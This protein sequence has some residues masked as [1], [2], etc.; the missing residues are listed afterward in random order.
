MTDELCPDGHHLVIRYGKFGKFLACE[1]FP[2]HKFTKRIEE[3]IDAL[4]PDSG[5][6]VAFRR[7]KRG[8]AFFG[9]SG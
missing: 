8:R 2:E 4:C 7:T 3:K 6:P 9:C 1:K 5:D